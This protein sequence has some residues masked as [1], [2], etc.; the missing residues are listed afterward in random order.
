MSDASAASSPDG[1][2]AASA[3]MSALTEDLFSAYFPLPYR[4]VATIIIGVWGWAFVLH[5]LTRLQ[6][7][8]ESLL[9]FNQKHNSPPLYQI[10]YQIG[11]MLLVVY[12]ATTA[13]LWI[14]GTHEFTFTVFGFDILPFLCFASIP[15][16][17]MF[18]GHHGHRSSRNRFMSTLKRISFG[19]LDAET[20]F[21]DIIT[22]DALTSYSKVLADGWIMVCMV[23]CGR[24]VAAIPDRTCGGEWVAPMI[25]SIP[26]LI[27]LR[28]CLTDFMR[29]NMQDY[30]HLLNAAK[31]STTF[32]VIILSVVKH[33]YDNSEGAT[34]VGALIIYDLWILSMLA[35]SIFSFCWDVH[36]DW[37][38]TIFVPA[39]KRPEMAHRG[40][41]PI[42]YFPASFY[43]LAV[44][45]DLGLRF[46]WSLKLSPHLYFFNDFEG[47]VFVLE[48]MELFRRWIWLFLRIE[49]EW[50]RATGAGMRVPLPMSELRPKD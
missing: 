1:A 2:H 10:V 8:V 4:V 38:L 49:T 7:N 40:L 3:G 31:Y 22:A 6:I 26:Y 9:R 11:T 15:V 43:Y 50:I 29:S 18:P 37:D 5:T 39:S 24:S 23:L 35:N 32:P 47:G 19:G 25:I 36:K 21:A 34:Y 46:T 17:F 44:V 28:Q 41:R 48:V 42:T 30:A 16:I 12:S 27:R 33:K 20:R 14:A 13:L 45:L